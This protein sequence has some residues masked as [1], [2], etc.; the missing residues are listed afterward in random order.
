[1]SDHW[2][3]FSSNACFLL[4]AFWLRAVSFASLL[5]LKSWYS[6]S[7]CSAS[8]SSLSSLK[9]DTN[10]LKSFSNCFPTSSSHCDRIALC[11]SWNFLLVSC[12]FSFRCLLFGIIS[13][14]ILYCQA[15][16]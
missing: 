7:A 9:V 11:F 1:M 10:L 5:N 3:T 14:V 16:N 8:L 2:L 12:L 13:Y 6:F 4:I 15:L